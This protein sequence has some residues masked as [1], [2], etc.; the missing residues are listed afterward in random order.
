MKATFTLLPGDGIG[1]EVIAEARKLLDAIATLFNHDFT[2]E[3]A[4]IGGAAIDT[5]G[6]P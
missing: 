4:L 1:T 6:D 3:E 2:V 5:T